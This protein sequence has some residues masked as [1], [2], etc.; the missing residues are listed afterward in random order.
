MF[1][2]TTP[3]PF[4]W[5]RLIRLRQEGGA[6]RAHTHPKACARSEPATK[7]SGLSLLLLCGGG[8]RWYPP[9]GYGLVSK[10]LPHHVAV[11]LLAVY[12]LLSPGAS[13][14]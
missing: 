10:R 6:S 14:C 2:P 11:R 12:L 1:G 3:A 8:V 4:T 9:F 13:P 7:I 5:H